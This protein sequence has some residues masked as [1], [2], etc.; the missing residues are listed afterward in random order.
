MKYFLRILLVLVVAAGVVFGVYYYT[1]GGGSNDN[2]VSL[3]TVTKPEATEKNSDR[4]LLVSLKD[5][6]FNLYK[7]GKK[8]ILSHNGKDFE[9]D[10]WSSMIDA[11]TPEM[12]YADFDGDDDKEILIKGVS[13][14]DSGTGEYIYNVYVLNPVKDNDGNEAYTVSMASRSTWNNILDE[15]IVEEL[16]QLKTCKKIAQFSMTNS[17]KSVAY[18]K[19]T[20]IAENGHAGYFRALQGSDGKYMTV[21]K[22]SKGIGVYTITKDNKIEVD[23]SVNISY[24]ESSTVQCAGSIHFELALDKSNTFYPAEKSLFF[25]TD[26]K[27]KVSNPKTSDKSE[28]SYTENNSDK[29]KPSSDIINDWIKYST[30]YD[31]TITTQT[32]S[33]AAESTDMKNISKLVITNSYIELTAKT[34]SSFDKKAAGKGEFSVIINEGTD[35]EYDIAYT[36]SVTNTGNKEVLKITFDKSYPKSEI[37]TVNINYGAK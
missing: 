2:Q 27:Y 29:S 17:G 20:G 32:Q 23:I 4:K 13:E 1:N 3:T 11:E 22:W 35:N 24:K 36:A 14:Q 6:G 21:N 30:K 33:Y 8:V 26:D 9:F 7:S 37:K 31:P 18:N 34:G 10:N 28:W 15:Y 12:H 5:E 25:I 16:T 19:T